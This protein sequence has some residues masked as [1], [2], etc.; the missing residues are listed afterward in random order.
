[1]VFL[2]FGRSFRTDF[3]VM[4]PKTLEPGLVE[5]GIAVES[6]AG[7]VIRVRGVIEDSGGPA[8]RLTEPLA[9]ELLDRE[10]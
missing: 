6:L 8:I 4:V 5:A 9:L 3:T 1:M 2:D 7:R 10:E